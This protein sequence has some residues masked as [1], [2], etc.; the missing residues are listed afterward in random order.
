MSD[1]A[2]DL[3]RGNQLTICSRP[4]WIRLQCNLPRPGMRQSAFHQNFARYELAHYC[5]RRGYGS[6][7]SVSCMIKRE[8]V[9]A[10]RADIGVTGPR[11][12]I[13]ATVLQ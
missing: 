5:G 9:A 4:P 3:S 2:G 12:L 8:N 10:L 1:F 6:S 11:F 7:G 13:V